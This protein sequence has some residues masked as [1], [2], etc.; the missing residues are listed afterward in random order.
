MSDTPATAAAT[1]E[2][3]SGF[4][5]LRS[6]GLNWDSL[7]LRLFTKGN[8]RF[9]N[10]T[11][12]DLSQ[13]AEDWKRLDDAARTRILRL[14]A[15]FVA[16]E[17]AVTEDLQ[18]FIRAMAAEGRLGDEMYLTQFAF[19]EAKHVQAFRLWLDALG[20]FDDLHKHVDT[21]PGYRTLFYEELPGSLDALLHD[22][23]PR[24]QVRASVT[25]NH[26]IEGSLALTGY[27]AWNHLCTVRDVFPGMR[28]I[29]RRIGDDE[30]RHMAWGTF[31]CRRHV[32]DDDANW[33]VVRERLDELLPHVTTTVESGET[34]S[35]DPA[36]QRY[37][38]PRGELVRY[39]GDRA[40]R[41]LGAIESARGVP[42]AQIDVD[43]SPEQLEERF[44][45]EDRE[46]MARVAPRD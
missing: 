12:I 46:V 28:E 37:E 2:R 30:R 7:P 3:R 13:D 41:R 6:G 8:A 25:Y 32:A 31:T 17:E 18:P 20:V 33:E 24:N 34:P 42:V 44:G 27:Y 11:D 39:A 29:V 9:W 1:G 40:L 19:E 16:G 10:P 14:C 38:L 21:N 36:E 23:S 35:D 15:L 4:H 26:V 45:E 43:A 22:P 5:S